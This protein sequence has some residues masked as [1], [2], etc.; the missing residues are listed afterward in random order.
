MQYRKFGKLDWNVSALGFGCMRLPVNNNDSGNINEEEAIRMIRTAVDAGVNYVDTAYPYH[1][2]M[3]EVVTGKALQDGYRDRVKLATKSPVWAIQ[4]PADF[5][6][7]LKEQLE[8]LRT[9]RIDFYLLH[10]LNSDRWHQIILKHD[11]LKKAEA[12]IKDGRIGH[13]GFSFHDHYRT[14]PEIVDGYDHWTFCQIQYNYMDIENQ[15]GTKGLQYAAAKGLGVVVMEPLL[16]G[17]LAN[18]P[19]PIQAVF[20]SLT[21]KR[22]AAEWALQWLWNQP[23]V[24]VVLSGMSAMEQVEANLRAADA[25]T[26]DSLKPAE[27]EAIDLVRRKYKERF[28]I[29]CTNCQ[30]C[31]PC[32]NGVAIPRIFELYNSGVAYDDQSGV[33]FTY[34]Q[35]FEANERADQ[36]IQCRICEEKC[37]QKIPVSEWM[38]KIHTSFT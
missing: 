27:L 33:R 29:P 34:R 12:A 30:Y 14:F 15:A 1:N 3:S 13:L 9:D 17:K 20:D 28:P 22:S 36:C 18:P 32:P 23:E 21:V 24:S 31:M 38:P 6:K 7:Y 8:K 19:Q 11:I 10:A 37:P 4:S 35:F 16:G 5:D 2:G 26:V 25:A